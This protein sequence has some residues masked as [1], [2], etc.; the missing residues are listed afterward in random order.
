MQT[1]FLDTLRRC[2]F[3]PAL[4]STLGCFIWLNCAGGGGLP[5]LGQSVERLS[6]ELISEYPHD[7]TAFTQ[8][9]IWCSGKLYES[10]GRYGDSRLRKVRLKDGRV[11]RERRLP[12]NFFGEG[13]ARVEDR[14][15]QL[16]W[17]SG[18]A[19]VYDL[20]TFEPIRQIR[21]SGE[22]WG[23]TFDGSWLVM[24]DGSDTLTFRDPASLVVWRRLPVRLEGRPVQWLNELEFAE[25]EIFANVWQS[26][27]IVRIDPETGQV[28]AV[29]DASSLPYKPRSRTEDVL[30]GIAYV[31]SRGTFLLTGKLWPKVYEVRFQ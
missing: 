31:P 23:L 5:V 14:L 1:P 10:T 20:K 4:I 25:G 9:L 27:Q 22:G 2:F 19:L 6:L 28:T 15:Y 29:I 13:L 26:D 24:S 7:A 16:T 30:N 3:R 11:V 8:G 17:R 18:T 21:Y 12:F